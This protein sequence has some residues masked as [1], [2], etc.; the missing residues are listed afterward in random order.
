MSSRA[1]DRSPIRPRCRL[2]ARVAPLFLAHSRTISNGHVQGTAPAGFQA[3]TFR[4]E[5]QMCESAID[6]S[7]MCEAAIFEPVTFQATIYQANRC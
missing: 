2:W 3:E 7:A 4:A 6:A 5:T 1:E